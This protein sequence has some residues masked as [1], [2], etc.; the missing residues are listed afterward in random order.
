MASLRVQP[1]VTSTT[2]QGTAAGH[3]SVAS[4]TGIPRHAV[5]VISHAT[6]GWVVE[7]VRV[8]D[9]TKLL[10]RQCGFI[11]ETSANRHVNNPQDLT[12]I[13]NGATVV[14]EEQWVQDLYSD[15]V[16]LTLANPVK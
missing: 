4:T 10:G 1:V 3:L 2:A 16:P 7:V 11:A 15:D 9:G 12:V 8:I 6:G 5:L 14:M 13:P